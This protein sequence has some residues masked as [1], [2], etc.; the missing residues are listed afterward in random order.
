MSETAKSPAEVKADLEKEYKKTEEVKKERLPVILPDAEDIFSQ[1]LQKRSCLPHSDV[2][3]AAM[4][5]RILY[6][7]NAEEYMGNPVENTLYIYSAICKSK[8]DSRYVEI[9]H[10][11][12][13]ISARGE[14][15]PEE[16]GIRYISKE[17]AEESAIFWAETASSLFY[18]EEEKA[19]GTPAAFITKEDECF[20]RDPFLKEVIPQ[21]AEPIFDSYQKDASYI[22]LYPSFIMKEGEYAGPR[23]PAHRLDIAFQMEVL[24]H[25]YETVPQRQKEAL[26]IEGIKKRLQSD[27]TAKKIKRVMSKITDLSKQFIRVNRA[28][29]EMKAQVIADDI[30][31]SVLFRTAINKTGY[32]VDDF[33]I[34][35]GKH[36]TSRK[37]EKLLSEAEETGIIDDVD[38]LVKSG[39]KKEKPG[40]RPHKTR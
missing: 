9:T 10:T 7:K 13:Y 32:A 4:A 17:E 2:L 31:A 3:T 33:D 14:E 6:S 24:E 23:W 39:L 11:G 22:V 27:E 20:C 30:I 35:S 12:K 18:R 19:G 38:R 21:K 26:D 36:I 37:L 29:P 28:L 8:S 5:T 1:T 25:Y 40:K 16:A 34:N 15:I